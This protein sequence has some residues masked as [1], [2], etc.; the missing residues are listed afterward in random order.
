MAYS[1]ANKAFATISTKRFETSLMHL[2]CGVSSIVRSCLNLV[3][4]DNDEIEQEKDLIESLRLLHG[5]G[6]SMLPIQGVFFVISLRATNQH[7]FS[8]LNL[9]CTFVICPC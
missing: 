2:F 8:F 6:V 5:F 4:D 3:T 1:S 7:V 9:Y